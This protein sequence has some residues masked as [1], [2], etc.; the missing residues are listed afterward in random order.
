MDFISQWKTTIKSLQ[1]QRPAGWQLDLA[2]AYSAIGDLHRKAG[3]TERALDYHLR[4]RDLSEQI[5]HARNPPPG[6]GPRFQLESTKTLRFVGICYMDL[7]KL[8][9]ARS[10]YSLH[11]QEV[12]GNVTSG[13]RVVVYFLLSMLCD[14]L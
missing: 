1:R 5:V 9:L 7:G 6:G 4:E 3:E 2:R 13:E 8:D 12:S 11:L 14:L 10:Y